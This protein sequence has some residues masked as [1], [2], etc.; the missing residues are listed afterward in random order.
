MSEQMSSEIA[1]QLADMDALEN[2]KPDV[3]TPDILAKRIE[4][5]EAKLS[6]YKKDAERYRA[7]RA[8]ASKGDLIGTDDLE[9]FDRG[10]DAVLSQDRK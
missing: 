4:H 8:V 1:A 5:L 10:F 9:E 7:Y 2:R 3:I 6:A